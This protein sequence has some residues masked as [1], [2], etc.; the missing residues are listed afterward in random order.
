MEKSKKFVSFV[1]GRKLSVYSL[2]EH[3]ILLFTWTWTQWCR[4]HE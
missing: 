2:Q 1:F 3:D 4:Q